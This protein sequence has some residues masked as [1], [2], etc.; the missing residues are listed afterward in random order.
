MPC[1]PKKPAGP[2][3][4][5]GKISLPKWL[6]KGAKNYAAGLLKRYEKNSVIEVKTEQFKALFISPAAKKLWKEVSALSDDPKFTADFA[7]LAFEVVDFNWRYVKPRE[8]ALNYRAT[9]ESTNTSTKTKCRAEKRC[10]RFRIDKHVN[11]IKITAEKLQDLI[12]PKYP[13]FYEFVEAHRRYEDLDATLKDFLDN[14]ANFDFKLIRSH[15]EIFEGSAKVR[16]G[17][18]KSFIHYYCRELCGFFLSSVN[19]PC[20]GIVA[21]LVSVLYPKHTLGNEQVRKNIADLIPKK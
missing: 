12:S 20:E 21:D 1:K 3:F 14:L 13:F 8:G 15:N 4:G 6:P 5:I 10:G 18:N 9:K 7:Y 16:L 2:G 19:R 11:K 17:T